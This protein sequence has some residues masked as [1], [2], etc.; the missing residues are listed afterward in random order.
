MYS[1]CVFGFFFNLPFLIADAAPFP[2][3]GHL[4]SSGIRVVS[5]LF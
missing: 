1:K 2:F 3:F 4:L 5:F